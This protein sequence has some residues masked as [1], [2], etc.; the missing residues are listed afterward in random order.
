M[1]NVEKLTEVINQDQASK[2]AYQFIKT[3]Y[4][5]RNLPESAEKTARGKGSRRGNN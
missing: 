1:K 2:K 3:V 4:R 5:F